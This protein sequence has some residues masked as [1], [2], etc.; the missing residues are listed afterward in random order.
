MP[1]GKRA[2]WTPER[3]D[4]GIREMLVV[5]LRQYKIIEYHDASKDEEKQ[6]IFAI[7]PSARGIDFT[8]YTE[9]EL[10]LVKK[11][12]N[13]AIEMAR[14]IVQRLDI[15]AAQAFAENDVTYRR[16]WRQTPQYIEFPRKGK[17]DAQQTDDPE[18]PWRS[19]SPG[20]E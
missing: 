8:Y 11:I 20:T 4:P 14:P 19:D 2:Q 3:F 9:Q 6:I 1:K 7:N 17:P 16:I 18:L 10:D 12:F 15:R 5:A 13:N